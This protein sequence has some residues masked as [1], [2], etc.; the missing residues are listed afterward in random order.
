MVEFL[1]KEHIY[2]VDGVIVPSVT[3]ILEKIFPD[4]YKGIPEDILQRKASYGRYL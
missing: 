2:L 1:E 4:K 3:Q